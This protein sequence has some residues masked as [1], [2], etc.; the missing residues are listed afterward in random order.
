MGRLETIHQR[1]QD[2]Q[3][4][5]LS[6]LTTFVKQRTYLITLITLITLPGRPASEKFEKEGT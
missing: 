4:N 1:R 5:S 3:I 2:A 6:I